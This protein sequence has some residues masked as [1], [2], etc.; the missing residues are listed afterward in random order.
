M[1]STF[2]TLLLGIP[3]VGIL[4]LGFFRVDALIA[5]PRARAVLGHPLSHRDR[6]GQI[7]CIEPDGRYLARISHSPGTSRA[8]RRAGDFPRRSAQRAV[9]RIS[10]IWNERNEE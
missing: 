4:L 8:A 5:K 3:I 6:D 7:V 1:Q 9:Q 2:D 10:V